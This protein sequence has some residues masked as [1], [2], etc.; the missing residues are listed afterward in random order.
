VA[1]N[2]SRGQVLIIDDREE[3]RYIFRR[4]LV[5]AGF[6]VEEAATG[7][8]GLAKAM[9]MPDL[10]ICDLNLPDMLGYEV[11]RRLKS[12]PATISIPV[13]QI[14]ASFVSDES[15]VQ[16]LKEGADSYLTQP[17]EP[18]VLVAHVD[19]LLRLSRAESLSHLSA[20]QW[21]TTFDALNDGLALADSDGTMIRANATFMQLL[22]L[23]ATDIEGKKLSDVFEANFG[24]RL[25]SFLQTTGKGTA[26]ELSH[27]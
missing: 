3:T 18:M 12:N 8:E 9:S 19:A 20:L 11:C 27:D 22:G 26:A 21:Q 13:L 14:S 16:A 10:V 25:E 24:T 6:A 5:R 4:I 15:K 23:V 1:E 17:V 7:S 2:Q